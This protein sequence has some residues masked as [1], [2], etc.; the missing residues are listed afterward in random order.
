MSSGSPLIVKE[1]STSF[2]LRV[3]KVHDIA[4]F[5]RIARR[6]IRLSDWIVVQQ[7]IESRYDWRVGV[8]GGQPAVCL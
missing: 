3:E 7:Y 5:F 8:I 6:F 2:S 4:E 1:P